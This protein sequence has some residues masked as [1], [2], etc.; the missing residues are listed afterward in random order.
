MASTQQIITT[1]AREESSFAPDA[2]Q[3]VKEEE[4]DEDLPLKW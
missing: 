4:K 3:N 1:G 2:A